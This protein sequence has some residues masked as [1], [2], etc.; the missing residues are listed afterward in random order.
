MK[1]V[2]AGLGK[3]G[4]P[5]AAVFAESGH[6]VVGVD[7]M[8]P[9]VDALNEG[10]VLIDEPGLPEMIAANSERILATT[11]YAEA[12]PGADITFIIVPTPSG[13]DGAFIND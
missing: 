9:V 1:V 5:M 4:L 7:P 10:R 13:D 11:S 3:L 8:Q 12:I 2:V 6:D